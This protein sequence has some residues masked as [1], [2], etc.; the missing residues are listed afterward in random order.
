[1]GNSECDMNAGRVKD[2]TRAHILEAAAA[3]GL[4]NGEKR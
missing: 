1:M 4:V 3:A 2:A